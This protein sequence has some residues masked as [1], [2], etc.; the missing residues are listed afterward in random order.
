MKAA[1]AKTRRQTYSTFPEDNGSLSLIAESFSSI[2]AEYNLFPIIFNQIPQI[3]CATMASILGGKFNDYY[4]H[5]FIID[6]RFDYEFNGGHIKGAQRL[7]DVANIEKLFFDQKY[8]KALIIFHC[9]FSHNRGPDAASILR[10]YDR[11]IN[12]NNYPYIDY[13]DVYILKGGYSEFYGEYSGLCEGKYV[14]M[15]DISHRRELPKTTTNFRNS[16]R[17]AK[18]SSS[19]FFQETFSSSTRCE[20]EDDELK[21]ANGRQILFQS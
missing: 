4:N 11:K 20:E 1:G 3:S 12:I 7:D 16:L 17:L 6:C 9:E 2:R 8:E 15:R 5:V 19:C 14:Q 18:V 21:P 10:N 13:P